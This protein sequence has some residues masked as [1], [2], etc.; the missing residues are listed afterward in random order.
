MTRG[1]KIENYNLSRTPHRFRSNW[2]AQIQ[3]SLVRRGLKSTRRDANRPKA[4]K[5]HAEF[6]PTGPAKPACP[7]R[8]SA[9]TPLK[10][11]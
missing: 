9:T 7:V 4:R 1:P 11:P 8:S 5:T 3:I 6:V 2:H 10:S